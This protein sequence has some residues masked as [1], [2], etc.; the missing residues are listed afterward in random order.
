[1]KK[2]FKS[3]IT[4]TAILA[5]GMAT[6]GGIVFDTPET[7][8]ASSTIAAPEK[9]NDIVFQVTDAVPLYNVRGYDIKMLAFPTQDIHLVLEKD[10][11]TLKDGTILYPIGND[12]YVKSTDVV[13][14]NL[15]LM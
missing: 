15:I 5:T 1:M 4:A 8:N 9:T 14:N 3:L 11:V 7:A 2:T 13:G 10:I 6:F 12:F